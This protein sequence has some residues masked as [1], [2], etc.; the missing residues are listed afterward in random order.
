[1]PLTSRSWVQIA[2][3]SAKFTWLARHRKKKQIVGDNGDMFD[4]HVEIYIR[5]RKI[6]KFKCT[7]ML[8]NLVGYRQRK[9]PTIGEFWLLDH[10]NDHRSTLRACAQDFSVFFTV[11]R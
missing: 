4:L 3:S 7:L 2:A 8:I 1:M 6:F 11:W 5:K 10:I 9:R